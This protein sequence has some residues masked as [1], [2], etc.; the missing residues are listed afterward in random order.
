MYFRCGGINELG[1]IF[2]VSERQI[3]VFKADKLNSPLNNVG[4]D[5]SPAILMP[6]YDEDSSTLFLTGRVRSFSQFFSFLRS[7]YLYFLSYVLGW[8]KN[9]SYFY[10]PFPS[11]FVLFIVYKKYLRRERPNEKYSEV[12]RRIKNF[13][14]VQNDDF[15]CIKPSLIQLFFIL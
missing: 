10:F 15:I 7:F 9:N 14:F 6:Y 11:K 1:L 13:Y 12:A 2:R 4:L 5:V 8:C 3:L